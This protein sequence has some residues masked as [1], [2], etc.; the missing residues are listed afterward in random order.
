LKIAGKV[1]YWLFFLTLPALLISATINLEFS[2]PWLYQNGFRKYN[3]SQTTGLTETELAK[4]ARGLISY[5]NSDEEYISLT[6]TKDG[7]AFELFNEREIV[8]LK[9]VKALVELNRRLLIGT[10]AYI[11]VYA[12][13]CLF[14]RRRKYWRRLARGTFI[15][16]IITAGVV[17]AL[18]LSSLVMDFDQIFLRF[19]YLAFTNDL[20]MLDP[21]RDYLIMLFP[22]GF[23]FD[24][25]VLFGQITLGVAA[26]L[27]GVS[28]W[29]LRKTKRFDSQREP[30]PD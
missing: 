3:V 18:G 22:E 29:Y 30:E 7:Q 20:W 24:T 28:A 19:H 21:S 16:S 12:G 25:A 13:M 9:D 5:F 27:G 14:W 15:G 2:S 4:A 10:A 1:A 8:H 11:G 26:A 6:V 23:W 17:I